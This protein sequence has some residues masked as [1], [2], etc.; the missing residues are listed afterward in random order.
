MLSSTSI[1]GYKAA[2]PAPVFKV[3]AGGK[4][5]TKRLDDALNKQPYLK[6]KFIITASGNTTAEIMPKV[7]RMQE[8]TPNPIEQWAYAKTLVVDICMGDS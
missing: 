1:K 3:P 7:R 2:F 4:H 8:D 5:V 6:M